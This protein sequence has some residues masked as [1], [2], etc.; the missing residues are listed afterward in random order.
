M[1]KIIEL[2]KVSRIYGKGGNQL[3][4]LSDIDLAI[5]Q[6]D[7]V[8]ITG[9]SGS[10]KSTLLNILGCMDRDYV[11]EYILNGNEV[12]NMSRNQLAKLRNSTFGFVV[13]DYALIDYYTVYKNVEIPLIY[14]KA[15]N[16]AQTHPA[17]TMVHH[18]FRLNRKQRI[19]QTLQELGIKDKSHQPVRELS[20]GQ[21]QRTA[22]ARAIV[23]GAEIIL[24][25]EPT[26]A[27]DTH[28]GE[29]VMAILEKLNR[30]GRTIIMVTHNLELTGRCNRHIQLENGM[31]AAQK[32]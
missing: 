9:N 12:H 26:G 29:Q 7:F 23:N 15:G 3:R 5:N 2:K 17:E 24:A 20:G 21:K 1:N 32:T 28:N 16:A 22:I 31:M 25:D 8:C 11:G 18:D 14:R 30:Q 27:L 13:Q 4:A 6:G 10:G 19:M